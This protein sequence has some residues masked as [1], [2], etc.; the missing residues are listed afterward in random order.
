MG[1]KNFV[2][3]IAEIKRPV[4]V[5]E[6]CGR[7]CGRGKLTEHLVKCPECGQLKDLTGTTEEKIIGPEGLIQA[8]SNNDYVQYITN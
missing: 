7:N 5:C 1:S 8:K 6:K 3:V 2:K 4:W